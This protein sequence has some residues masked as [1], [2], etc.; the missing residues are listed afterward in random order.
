MSGL[1]KPGDG[2]A[3]A[4]PQVNGMLKEK[5]R[6]TFPL[7]KCENDRGF[8]FWLL[9]RFTLPAWREANGRGKNKPPASLLTKRCLYEQRG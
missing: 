8:S 3:R 2:H 6:L 7:R 5:R 4:R 9:G 1:P